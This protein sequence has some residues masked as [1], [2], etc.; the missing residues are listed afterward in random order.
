MG[1]LWMDTYTAFAGPGQ[2]ESLATLEEGKF[3]VCELNRADGEG[4]KEKDCD[5]GELGG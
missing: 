4:G 2:Q 1:V 3:S 5:G